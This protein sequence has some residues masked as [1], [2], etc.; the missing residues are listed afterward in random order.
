MISLEK[1]V[2]AKL[3]PINNGKNDPSFEFKAS[4]AP[5][6]TIILLPMIEVGL[7][8]INRKYPSLTIIKL[9]FR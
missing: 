1:N 6:R 9:F 4:K 3:N 5:K 2:Y 7:T 8:L